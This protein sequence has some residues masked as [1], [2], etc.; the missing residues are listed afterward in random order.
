[1]ALGAKALFGGAVGKYDAL[2]PIKAAQG[3]T[4]VK[5]HHRTHQRTWMSCTMVLSC[6]Y[7][8]A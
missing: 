7:I 1:M 2:A 5:C 4:R 8:A 3:M 6:V